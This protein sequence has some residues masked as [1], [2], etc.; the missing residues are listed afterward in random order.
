MTAYKIFTVSNGKINEGAK[1]NTLK[2]S[3]S[4]VKIPVIEIG[5][6]GRGRE[7]GIIS[8]NLLPMN[9]K[10][11]ENKEEVRVYSASLGQTRS[12][13]P[14]LFETEE[15]TTTEKI[16]VVFRTTPGFRGSCGHTGD[17]NHHKSDREFP[18]EIL[19]TGYTAQGI[20]GRMGGGE[21]LVALMPLNTVF[22]TWYT[23]R[24]YGDPS[25]HYYFWNGKTLYGLTKTERDILD[26]F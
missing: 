24:L 11:W 25:E 9:F 2:L 13:N 4:P 3:N 17:L 14:K 23:G 5:E 1:I 12:G 20:A 15:P 26:L 16:L 21:Q 8:V 7:R 6:T 22:R 18:G 19:I 10:K